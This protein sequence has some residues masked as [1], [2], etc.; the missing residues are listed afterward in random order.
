MYNDFELNPRLLKSE[1]MQRCNLLDCQ[2]A[3]CLHG[4]WVGLKEKDA[5]LNCQESIKLLMFE[6]YKDPKFW[7]ESKIE[8]DPFI[9][10]GLVLKTKVVKN[11]EHYGGTACIFLNGDHKCVLQL[12]S[13]SLG[14]H[15][16][17]L[18]PFYCIL[19]PLDLDKNGKITLDET[20]LLLDEPGSCLRYSTNSVALLETFEEELRYLLGNQRYQIIADQ[21]K[22]ESI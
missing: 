16:W 20:F 9:D 22:T 19:H 8:K 11:A 2:G 21:N 7:F 10:G 17:S 18:K 13:E 4:V 1:N 5:I 12:A 15:K 6:Q 14:L 3:C